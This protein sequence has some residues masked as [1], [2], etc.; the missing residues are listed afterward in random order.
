[1]DFKNLMF[2]LVSWQCF[3][4]CTSA[5]VS[6]QVDKVTWRLLV[7]YGSPY[8]EGKLDFISELH[9]VMGKW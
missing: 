3:E 6:N 4:H 9:M 8:E 1:V 7:V 2:D 5:I